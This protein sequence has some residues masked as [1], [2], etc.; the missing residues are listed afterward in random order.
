M[1][2]GVFVKDIAVTAG[3]EMQLVRFEPG[4][5][6]PVHTHEQPEFLF[7][8]EGDLMQGGVRLGPGWASVA[9]AGTVDADVYSEQGCVFVLEPWEAMEFVDTG[10]RSLDSWVTP[11]EPLTA[12][13]AVG[14][15]VTDEDARA[16]GR[17]RAGAAGDR[18]IDVVAGERER[19][20]RD[21]DRLRAQR[22]AEVEGARLARRGRGPVAARVELDDAGRVEGRAKR[23]VVDLLEEDGPPRQIE[24]RQ[25]RDGAHG[26]QGAGGERPCAQESRRLITAPAPATRGRRK[27]G[28][29]EREYQ[30]EAGARHARMLPGAAR[31]GYA[32]EISAG[33]AEASNAAPALG[34]ATAHALTSAK[35][36]SATGV[37]RT[38]WLL[39]VWS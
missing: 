7:I 4:A 3:W 37:A 38:G 34:L 27:S 25:T 39:C 18:T 6:F 24:R 9:S 28:K 31:F 14:R 21:L 11:R 13:A 19:P 30:T 26:R 35:A 1:A 32:G 23:R 5:R 36:T 2:P 12:H 16:H 8:L 10:K 15:A 22:R 33:P 20:R 29:R 17:A